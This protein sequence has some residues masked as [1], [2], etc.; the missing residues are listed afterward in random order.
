MEKL[1]FNEEPQ[2][3]VLDRNGKEIE[4]KLLGFIRNT[5]YSVKSFSGAGAPKASP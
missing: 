3:K 2:E 5:P 4:L 1:T